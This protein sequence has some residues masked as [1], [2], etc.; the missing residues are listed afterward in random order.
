MRKKKQQTL[1]HQPHPE[2]NRSHQRG[3]TDV[4]V[5]FAAIFRPSADEAFRVLLYKHVVVTIRVTRRRCT[6][7]RES[8]DARACVMRQRHRVEGVIVKCKII[9][10]SH[11]FRLLRHS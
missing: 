1:A 2:K 3:A 4:C 10:D 6:S 9:I 11:E 7:E 8:E 5:P